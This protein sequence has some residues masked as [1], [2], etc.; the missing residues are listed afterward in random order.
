MFCTIGVFEQI[1]P[2]V[3]RQQLALHFAVGAGTRNLFTAKK[4]RV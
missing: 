2:D 3:H 4:S 1:W